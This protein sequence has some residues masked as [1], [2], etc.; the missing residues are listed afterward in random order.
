MRSSCSRSP[1]TDLRRLVNPLEVRLV[2]FAHAPHLPLPRSFGRRQCSHELRERRPRLAP[3]VAG[4]LKAASVRQSWPAA[5][6]CVK[7]RPA[8]AGPMPGSSCNARKAL[9][10]ILR[11]VRP[12]QHREHVLH[13]RGFEKL[14]PAVLHVGDVAADQFQFQHVAV[15]R[16]AEQHRLALERHAAL[17]RFQHARHH[18]VG[19][20][21]DRPP[22]SRSAAARRAARGA[23]GSFGTGGCPRRSAHW[24]HRARPG[25]S[26]SFPPA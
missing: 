3:P 21:P 11:I 6:K 26:D 17:A 25:S 15:M 20:A 22:P 2:P 9:I 4:A 7:Q 1:R 5:S 13:V 23:A 16:A 24:R 18:V 19:L 12:A 10:A 14:Q 8:F